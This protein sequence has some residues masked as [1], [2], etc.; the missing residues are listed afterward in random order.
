MT[1]QDQPPRL[2]AGDHAK[3]TAHP[4]LMLLIWL[5]GGVVLGF[6]IS[7]LIHLPISLR[8][9]GFVDIILA[10]G[11]F[12]WA[13]ATFDRVKTDVKLNTPADNLATSGPY[14]YTRNPIYLAMIALGIGFGLA[15]S[16]LWLIAGAIPFYYIIVK[17]VIEPEEAYMREKF[18]AEYDAYCQRVR[19]WL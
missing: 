13:L 8:L 6:T 1:D 7:P 12:G 15:I 14:A 10:F 4:P 16:N 5:V 11:F 19:R 2:E 18:G 9:I 3:A 17:R